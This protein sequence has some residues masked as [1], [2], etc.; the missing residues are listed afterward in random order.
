[1]TNSTKGMSAQALA[2]I[3]EQ[4]V[5]ELTDQ[6][7]SFLK[8]NGTSHNPPVNIGGDGSIRVVHHKDINAVGAILRTELKVRG[9]VMATLQPGD[10]K[11][12]PGS[13]DEHRIIGDVQG[14]DG[15][16]GIYSFILYKKK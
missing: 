15:S 6:S 14:S 11:V 5:A 4:A 8:V 9:Q 2:A 16:L 3:A 1:M 12:A 7:T 10:Q 13:Y